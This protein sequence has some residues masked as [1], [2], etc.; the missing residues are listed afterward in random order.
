LQRASTLPDL[1]GLAWVDDQF[2]L[3]VHDAKNPE[4]DRRPRVSR[5]TLEA[6]PTRRQLYENAS[7]V[8]PVSEV[9]ATLEEIAQYLMDQG[10]SEETGDIQ[11]FW[12]NKPL[13]PTAAASRFFGVLCLTRG[14]RA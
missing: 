7:E 4:E 10:H 13:H 5:P 8:K 3:A 1:S 9:F 11:D 12:P 14:P 2:L 6:E